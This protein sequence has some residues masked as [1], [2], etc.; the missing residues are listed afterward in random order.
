M[1]VIMY[2]TLVYILYFGLS[3]YNTLV[4]LYC[5]LLWNHS[6]CGD[7]YLSR[8]STRVSYVTYLDLQIHGPALPHDQ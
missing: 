3:L 2:I 7:L 8:T 6:P 1:N 4:M 5:I